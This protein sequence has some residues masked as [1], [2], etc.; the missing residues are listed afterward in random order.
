MEGGAA[1]TISCCGKPEIGCPVPQQFSSFEFR[2][3]GFQSNEGP[4][5]LIDGSPPFKITR[6]NAECL[7]VSED[8]PSASASPNSKRPPPFVPDRSR[9]GSEGEHGPG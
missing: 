9:K 1:I 3:P 7:C 6:S 4:G 2:A 8:A 5:A